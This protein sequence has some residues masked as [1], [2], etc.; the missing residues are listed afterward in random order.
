MNKIKLGS[1]PDGAMLC[2][3]D[4][5]C[6][7]PKIP[8]GEGLA[9]L[10]KFLETRDNKQI[11]SYTFMEPAEVVLKS[12]IF[13]FDEKTFKQNHGTAI[14]TKFALRYANLFM[15]DFEGKLLENFEKKPI[16]WWRYIDVKFFIWEHFE[17]SLKVLI[18]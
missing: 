14:E 15:A 2:I 11:S 10:L 4:I 8:L 12:K 18:K 6:L 5:V 9:S 3:K 16:I 1:L 7:Y 13:E 17:E